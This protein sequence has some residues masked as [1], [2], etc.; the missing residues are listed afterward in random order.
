MIIR[1]IEK[2]D[3]EAMSAIYNYY[4]ENTVFTF[5]EDP[6]DKQYF[7]EKLEKLE[8]KYPCLA[9]E[10]DGKLAGFAYASPYRVKPAYRY[11]AESTIYLDYHF[12]GRGYGTMLYSELL[13]KL[14]QAGIRN[15]IAVLGL[16]NKASEALHKKLGFREEGRL[17]E[18]GWKFNK[19]IDIG[20]WRLDLEKRGPVEK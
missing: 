20:F 15:V 1:N 18:V 11:T 2:K 10:E 8:G 19:W 13:E 4:I 12:A 7:A 5:D 16:P 9:L 14:K 3:A 6:S 17:R